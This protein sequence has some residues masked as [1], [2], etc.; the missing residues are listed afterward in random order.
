MKGM[1]ELLETPSVS[2]ANTRSVFLTAA[3]VFSAAPEKSLWMAREGVSS[4]ALV[5]F[6]ISPALPSATATA[7]LSDIYS[8]CRK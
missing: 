4:M 7:Q 1:K 3:P 5:F 2:T 6:N 8:L